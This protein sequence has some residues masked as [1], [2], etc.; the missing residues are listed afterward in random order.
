MTLLEI[1]DI[2]FK[3]KKFQK[4]CNKQKTLV[5]VYGQR[6][7]KLIRRRLDELLAANTLNDLRSLPGPRCH[8]LKGNRAG[9]LSVDLDYPY[10]LIFKPAND[11][12]LQKKHGGLDWT[13]ITTVEITGIEDTHE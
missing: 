8:E 6:R 12:I 1:V 7:A 9:Q 11:P 5:R 13:R 3:I 2:L 4:E 10:R